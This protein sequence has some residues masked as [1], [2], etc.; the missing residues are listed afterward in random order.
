MEGVLAGAW[1]NEYPLCEQVVAC[2]SRLVT[3]G[4]GSAI[5]KSGDTTDV[6]DDG[7]PACSLSTPTGIMSTSL[8]AP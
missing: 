7:T 2:T 6:M 3:Q 1:P 4:D 8:H 5:A